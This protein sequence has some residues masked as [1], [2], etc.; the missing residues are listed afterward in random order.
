MR[1]RR[2]FIRIFLWFWLAMALVIVG[3]FFS[4]FITER[5]EAGP[6]WR[7]AHSALMGFYAQSITEVFERDGRDAIISYL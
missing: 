2:L 7:G 6:P 4:S 5:R 1:L 3:L